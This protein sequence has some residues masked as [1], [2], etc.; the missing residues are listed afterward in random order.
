M[1][2]LIRIIY[3]SKLSSDSLS[4]DD[5]T[6]ILAVAQKNNAAANI[7]GF[8]LFNYRNFL[9]VLEGPTQAVMKIYESIK[10]DS[11]HHDL[12]LVESRAILQ[13][14]FSQWRMGFAKIDDD[15][16]RVD[17]LEQVDARNALALLK[18]KA[19]QT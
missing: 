11:R 2:D 12:K 16:L 14:E 18:Q 15:A 10:Q 6:Q 5:I 3:V 7:S 4:S 13:R 9:Q 1:S 8:L 17:A 19:N